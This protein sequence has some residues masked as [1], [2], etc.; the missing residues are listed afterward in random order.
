MVFGALHLVIDVHDLNC[1]CSRASLERNSQSSLRR[2]S[3]L[4]GPLRRSSR[5]VIEKASIGR[6]TCSSDRKH[7]SRQLESAT[8]TTMS[9]DNDSSSPFGNIES[10]NDALEVGTFHTTALSNFQST[11][12][13]W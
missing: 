10:K 6:E 13:F 4:V 3:G 5:L 2:S 11:L 7:P 1:L 12:G 8:A 9:T